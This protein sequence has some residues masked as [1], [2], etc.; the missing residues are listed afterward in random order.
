MPELRYI[1]RGQGIATQWLETRMGLSVDDFYLTVLEREQKNPNLD[2]LLP[3]QIH[4][5]LLNA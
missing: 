2:P 4:A 1:V 5:F 3:K